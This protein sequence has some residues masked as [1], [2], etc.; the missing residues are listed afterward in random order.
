MELYWVRSDIFQVGPTSR[1]TLRVL[2]HSKNKQ[3]K[4]V[5]AD[6][7]GVIQLIGMRK[8]DPMPSFKSLP[9]G[10]PITHITLGTGE[11]Q[12]AK[13][14]YS[15]DQTV[16]GVNKKGKE[17][18]RFNTNLTEKIRCLQ[19]H[20]ATLW[21]S[22]EY[23]WNQFDDA[24]DTH[25][26][27]AGD[28]VN[29]FTC[30]P[31]TSAD[32]NAILA[33]QDRYLRMLQGADLYY[34]AAV[35]GAVATVV[36]AGGVRTEG[37]WSRP[38]RQGR[39]EV[40]YGTDSGALGQM[41]L[42]PEA[43]RRGWLLAGSK[44]RK[45]GVWSVSSDLDYTKDGVAEVVVGR[46]DGSLE[47]YGFD[48]NG[49]PQAVFSKCVNESITSAGGGAI[50]S[51]GTE[52]CVL[53]TYSGKVI[54]FSSEPFHMAALASPE[55]N[56]KGMRF[57]EEPVT[58]GQKMAALRGEIEDLKRQ[59]EG[60]RSKYAGV[61]EDLIS[62]NDTF[63]INDK[64]VLNADDAS[65]T[66]TLETPMPIFTV[67]V[68][69][70][71][72]LDLLDTENN[73]AIVSRSPPEPENGNFCM[74]TYRCQESSNR[75]EVRLRGVEGQYGTLQVFVVPRIS[76]KTCS[77]C[78][79]KIKPLC[80]Q[81]RLQ[82]VDEGVP[83]NELRISGDFKMQEIHGWVAFCLP[84]VPSRPPGED[85]SYCFRSSL[86]GTVLLCQYRGGEGVFRSDSI[87]SLAIL[88]EAIT[89]EA[90]A[91]KTQIKSSFELDDGSLP[92]MCRLIDPKLRYQLSLT[93]KV[94]LIEA[95]QEMKVQE[96]D[97]SFLDPSYSEILDNHAAIEK[98]FK[99]QPRQLEY[100]HGIVK[101]LYID[102]HRFKGQNVKHKIGQLEEVLRHYTL[103]DLTVFMAQP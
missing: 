59:V 97:V 65:Y 12:D 93:Q 33:C 62:V 36:A 15:A 30:A 48:E 53:E 22:G 45:G 2:P 91:R 100:L 40:Y 27:M 14:F 74:A 44:E 1:G 19:A 39:T 56:S 82:S 32:H 35:D 63:R 6:D 13:I 85:A 90:T 24:K 17:F 38:L 98:E 84:D 96:E 61:S 72:P 92:H 60:E 7:T 47:V 87:T 66:L 34:E 29:D 54:A 18:F 9:T 3:Q 43:V 8:G 75:I 10:I 31:V 73:G 83:L 11:G 89:K 67:A 103:E 57:P 26:Y 69:S 51:A 41:F 79:Y 42:D 28:R 95:L 52:D 58:T 86:L 78:Q 94:K 4:F 76:P 55:V 88:K 77:V 23:V 71:V 99:Q 50:A 68:Q 102:W 21:T 5:I 80:L 101:D 20:E 64:F 25:F 16:Q 37:S 81:Q 49:E 46:D 70:D